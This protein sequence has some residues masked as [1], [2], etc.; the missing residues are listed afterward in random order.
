MGRGIVVTK[1]E[2]TLSPHR[3]FVLVGVFALVLLALMGRSS[4]LA[5]TER[6]FLQNEGEARATR[7][8]EIRAH[9]GII[10]DRNGHPLAVSTPMV[11]VWMDPSVDRL[12][13]RDLEVVAE[14]LERPADRL[15]KRLEDHDKLIK[16][17]QSA[18]EVIISFHFSSNLLSFLTLPR[19]IG[20]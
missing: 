9:R 11:S 19:S 17:H 4:F 3:H 5:V 6:K 18:V 10:S 12:D 2:R 16:A 8:A 7:I 13:D 14:L 1:P 15:K 20:N